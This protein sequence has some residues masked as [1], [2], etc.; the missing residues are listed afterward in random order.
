MKK[1]VSF[2]KA[3]FSGA[4]MLLMIY[5][6]PHGEALMAQDKIDLGIFRTAPDEVEVRMRPNF[7][8]SASQAFSEIRFTLRWPA[9]T[10]V[11][12]TG[13][14]QIPPFNLNYSPNSMVTF[15]GYKYQT[16]ILQS[17]FY[18][19]FTD[20]INAG[21]EVVISRIYHT[22][23]SNFIFGLM[24]A[25]STVLPNTDYFFEFICLDADGQGPCDSLGAYEVQGD[26]YTPFTLPVNVWSVLLTFVAILL[27]SLGVRLRRFKGFAYS[28]K[29]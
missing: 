22:G 9:T 7:D 11:N 14:E 10:F 12:I 28:K 8:I 3:S 2:S 16:L 29:V 26:I 18:E 25:T 5:I 13:L 21:E 15:Q 19:N 24:D 20:P 17:P 1:K 4:I 23:G 27:A 6:F